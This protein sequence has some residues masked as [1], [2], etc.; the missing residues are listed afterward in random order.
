MLVTGQKWRVT[1][2]NA[3]IQAIGGSCSYLNGTELSRKFSYFYVR[4]CIC[5]C[6]SVIW[7]G[8]RPAMTSDS[9]TYLP[10]PF[11][12]RLPR[13]C[14]VIFGSNPQEMVANGGKF[15]GSL[16]SQVEVLTK[17]AEAGCQY[18]DLDLQSAQA[19]KAAEIQKLKT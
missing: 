5:C 10:R 1:G 16:A 7:R 12:Q 15:K 2:T 19:L 13:V 18:V 8:L 4:D 11:P 6:A 9:S 3:R 14:V 17:A